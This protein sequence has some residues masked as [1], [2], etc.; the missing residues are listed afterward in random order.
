MITKDQVAKALGA[1]NEASPDIVVKGDK[2]GDLGDAQGA[3]NGDGDDKS[4]K[5]EG[6][7]MND[8]YGNKKES[9]KNPA[10]KS[11]AAEDD[12][13]EDDGDDDETEKSFRD[14]MSSEIRTKIDVSSFLRSLVDHNAKSVDGLRAALQKSNANSNDRTDVVLDSIEGLQKSLSNIGVVLRAVCERIG[15][16]ENQPQVAKSVTAAGQSVAK[17]VVAPVS[18]EFIAEAGETSNDGMYKS[19]NGKAP[20]VQKSMISDAICNLVMKGEAKDTDV[21]NFET[22]GFIPG[23]LDSKLR[24]VLN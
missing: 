24:S 15:V 11:M 21:I 7:D 17:S 18:R 1:L 5:S 13:S 2:D 20:H 8:K 14:D 22:N 4:L 10:K 3:A 9:D 19:L 23:E 12:D 16:I 6:E